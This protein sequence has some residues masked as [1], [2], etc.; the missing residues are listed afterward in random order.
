MQLA[1]N[2]NIPPPN[3]PN[4]MDISLDEEGPELL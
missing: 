2:Y 1:P 3:F 4:P